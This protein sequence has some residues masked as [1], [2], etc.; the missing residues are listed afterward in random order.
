M[1]QVK[2]GKLLCPVCGSEYVH[3]TKID[4]FPVG[5][6]K[7]RVHLDCQGITLSSAAQAGGHGR[8]NTV[9]V[10]FQCENGHEFRL[11]CDFHK[12]ETFVEQ[13]T[14]CVAVGDQAPTLWRD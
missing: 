9:C 12:G 5:P 3:V 10:T 11:C 6:A 14:A 4:A 2:D 13:D 1:L 8:G 7:Q